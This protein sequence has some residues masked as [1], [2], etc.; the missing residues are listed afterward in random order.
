MLPPFWGTCLFMCFGT[1]YTKNRFKN[2]KPKMGS[3]TLLPFLILV[4]CHYS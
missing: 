1:I 2:I 4:T 3:V